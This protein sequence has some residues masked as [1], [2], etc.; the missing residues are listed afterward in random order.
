[1]IYDLYFHQIP[2]KDIS[3]WKDVQ[4][5]AS[6]TKKLS[7][8]RKTTVSQ[9]ENKRVLLVKE[10]VTCIILIQNIEVHEE[11]QNKLLWVLNNQNYSC[12]IHVN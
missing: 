2:W 10:K 8:L 6:G 3:D 12:Q 4:S 11:H 9:S 5:I 7:S 1:M